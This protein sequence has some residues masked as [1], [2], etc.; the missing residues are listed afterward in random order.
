MKPT[1][2]DVVYDFPPLLRKAV[3]EFSSEYP[4]SYIDFFVINGI[5]KYF[6]DQAIEKALKRNLTYSIV[7]TRFNYVMHPYIFVSGDRVYD[8]SVNGKL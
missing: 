1:K 7:E 6:H 8:S 4:G 5:A 3:A 2:V